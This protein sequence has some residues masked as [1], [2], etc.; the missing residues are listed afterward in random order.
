[1][2]YTHVYVSEATAAL[3][4]DDLEAMCAGFPEANARH[5]VTGIMFLVGRHFVQVLEGEREV[6]WSLIHNIRKDKRSHGFHTLYHGRLLRR[7][8]PSWNMR[9]MRLDDHV[10][11]NAPAM[12][13]LRDRLRA[14]MSRELSRE[15]T[16]RLLIELPRLLP[17]E[18]YAALKQGQSASDRSAAQPQY[19][20]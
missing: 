20:R 2:L 1:M 14:L 7:R 6:V 10:K 13:H 9:W 3:S 5:A 17:L 19:A 18:F 16:Q 12:A 4:I 8:F 15:S 11:L